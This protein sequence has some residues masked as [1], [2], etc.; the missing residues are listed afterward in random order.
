MKKE[1]LSGCRKGEEADLSWCFPNR[2]EE[3]PVLETCI[4][5]R[6]ENGL[7][8]AHAEYLL[9]CLYYDKK[10][11]VAAACPVGKRHSG[12]P[13]SRRRF[14]ESGHLRLQPEGGKRKSP[15]L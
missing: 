10:Q 12:G 7:S 14:P 13:C 9:G 11:Y 15:V 6:K 3:I 4:R 2:L 5:L 1:A 8:A